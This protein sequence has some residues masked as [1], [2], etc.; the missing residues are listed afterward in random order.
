MSQI[1]S[2]IKDLR[3]QQSQAQIAASVDASQSLISRWEAGD[4]P[5]AADVALR[6]AS[7][8]RAAVRRKGAKAK[9]AGIS[10]EQPAAQPQQ[11]AQGGEVAHG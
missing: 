1:Q 11:P 5:A 9:D 10:P 4:I 6:L 3:E 8:H 2:F 7:L